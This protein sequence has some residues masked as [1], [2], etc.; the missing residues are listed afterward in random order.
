MFRYQKMTEREKQDYDKSSTPPAK[1]L[2]TDE[3]CMTAASKI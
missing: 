1:R 2:K 3:N